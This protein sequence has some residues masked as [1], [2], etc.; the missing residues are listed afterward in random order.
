MKRDSMRA[1]WIVLLVLLIGSEGCGGGDGELVSGCAVGNAVPVAVTRDLE[2]AAGELFT[3]IRAGE[4]QAIYESSASLLQKERTPDEFLTPIA[5]AANGLGIP[6]DLR[7]DQVFMICFDETFP[8]QTR[9]ICQEEGEERPHELIVTGYPVQATLIQRGSM[10]DDELF[11]STL[12]HNEEGTWKLAGF[13]SKPA[14]WQG[15][16]WAK[17][18]EDSD[19]HR[20]ADNRRNAALLLNVAIDLVVPCSWVKPPEITLLQR[21]QQRINVSNLPVETP[22]FWASYPDTFKVLRVGYVLAQDGLGLLFQYQ[23]PM[24]LED[25]LAQVAYADRLF[26]YIQVTFPEYKEVFGSCS[27]LAYD[28]TDTKKTFSREYSLGSNP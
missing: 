17:W 20:L 22:D 6:E 12:W 4:W 9:V 5:R 16:D 7:V 14:T 10:G 1:T 8:P 15:R 23:P 27:L 2:E 28:P 19:R 11:I 13:F 26:D 24:A 25:S 21:Q 18:A 3:R